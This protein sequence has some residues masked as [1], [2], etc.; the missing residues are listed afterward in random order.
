MGRAINRRSATGTYSARRNTGVGKFRWRPRQIGP[1]IFLGAQASRL[2]RLFQPLASNAGETPALPDY[3]RLRKR[4]FN[5]TPGAASAN[6]PN[7][8]SFAISFA[9][10][11]NAPHATR[12][13]VEPTEIDRKR[14]V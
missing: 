10:R 7:V 12:A 1:V 9:A 3:W 14:V 5:S 8:P 4:L 11:M 6:A 2:H 13:S